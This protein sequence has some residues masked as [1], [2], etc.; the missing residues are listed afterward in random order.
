LS[1]QPKVGTLDRTML[2]IMNYSAN[3]TENRGKCDRIQKK[4]NRQAADKMPHKIFPRREFHSAAPAA[5]SSRSVHTCATGSGELGMTTET[6][7]E[8]RTS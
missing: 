8:K 1:F 5:G 4:N 3:G 6:R 2:R 7:Y